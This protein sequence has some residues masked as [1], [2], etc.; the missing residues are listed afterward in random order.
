MCDGGWQLGGGYRSVFILLTRFLVPLLLFR[1][2]RIALSSTGMSFPSFV[3]P[4]PVR[5]SAHRW[6]ILPLFLFRRHSLGSRN[7]FS[8]LWSAV[9][10]V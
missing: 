3:I 2:L 1:R 5:H 8:T 4:Y 7:S 6:P 10:R 9:Y